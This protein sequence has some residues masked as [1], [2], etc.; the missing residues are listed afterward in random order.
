MKPVIRTILRMS[1]YQ[2]LYMDRIPDSA[3][4]NEGVK[5]AERRKL[6]GLKGFVNGVLRKVS[7]EKEGLLK[8]LSSPD[9]PRPDIRFSVPGWLYRLW[10]DELGKEQAEKGFA[11][12]FQASPTT[13][14]CNLSLASKEEITESLKAQGVS[15]LESPLSGKALM[16]S[17]YDYLEGLDAFSKGWIQVQDASSIL[18]GEAVPPPL[19]AYVLDICAAPGGKASIWPICSKERGWWKPG[20]SPWPRSSLLKKISAGQGFPISA[21]RYGTGVCL[22]RRP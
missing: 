15:V 20:I 21:L 3:A 7:R 12:F 14:R 13:V 1:L 5:L 19:G 8:E 16:I 4:C 9:F 22:I 17:G 6:S 10:A 18:S 11:A 2:I